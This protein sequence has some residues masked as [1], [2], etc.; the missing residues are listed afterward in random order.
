MNATLETTNADERGL[1]LRCPQCG[2]RNRLSYQRVGQTLRCG[3]CHTNLPS[4]SAA[5]TTLRV[6]VWITA[7]DGTSST[8]LRAA[9]LMF[10]VTNMPGFMSAV[11]GSGSMYMTMM[12]MY[13]SAGGQPLPYQLGYGEKGGN[14]IP[15][16]AEL[17]FEI[18]LIRIR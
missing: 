12:Q 14:G 1:V 6:P 9:G 15:P 10:T 3:Q 5:I 13:N 18:E 11:F 4:P 17:H 7:S 2:Q 16:K 8:S